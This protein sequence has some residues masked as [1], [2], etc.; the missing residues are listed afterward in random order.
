MTHNPTQP[1]V[2]GRSRWRLPKAG[3]WSAIVVT[4]G[5]LGACGSESGNMPADPCADNPCVTVRGITA[6]VEQINRYPELV[7]ADVSIWDQSNSDDQSV[8]QT[9]FSLVNSDNQSAGSTSNA[10]GCADWKVEDLQPGDHPPVHRVCFPTS[11]SKRLRLLFKPLVFEN[12]SRVDLPAGPLKPA[13]SAPQFAQDPTVTVTA[14]TATATFV[15]TATN[16]SPV[17]CHTMVVQVLGALPGDPDPHNQLVF[18]VADGKVTTYHEV[19]PHVTV[20][21]RLP[22]RAILSVVPAHEDFRVGAVGHCQDS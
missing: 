13:A 14:E 9:N 10:P 18:G 15:V 17:P 12:G 21:Q 2:P 1:A 20:T 11:G 3:I 16:P 5:L 6:V 19:A 4:V 8:D 22:A 7:T